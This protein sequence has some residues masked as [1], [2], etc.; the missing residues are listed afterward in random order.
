MSLN[1]LR[2][3]SSGHLDVSRMLWGLSVLA[4]IG[5]AGA[6]LVINHV[7]SIIEFGTG[8]GLLLAGGGT[9]TALKDTAVAR[10]IGGGQ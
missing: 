5:Y 2:G 7:F 10:A 8:M 9:A 6:H 3:P 4:G 1:F